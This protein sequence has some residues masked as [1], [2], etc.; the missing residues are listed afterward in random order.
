MK[1]RM[2]ELHLAGSMGRGTL[3]QEELASARTGIRRPFEEGMRG[4]QGQQ[5]DFATRVRALQMFPDQAINP[6]QE[7][8]GNLTGK[9]GENAAELR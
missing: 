3:A 7:A 2:N 8:L 4:L 5:A 9:P 1:D 6:M